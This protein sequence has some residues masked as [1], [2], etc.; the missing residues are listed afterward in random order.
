MLQT[1]ATWARK[2]AFALLGGLLM[3]VATPHGAGAAGGEATQAAPNPTSSSTLAISMTLYIQGLTLGT[4]ELTSTVDGSAYRAVSR[5]KTEGI[6]TLLWRQTIQATASGRIQ[7]DGFQP[8]LYDAFV[9]KSDGSNEQISLTYGDNGP[10][11]LFVDPPFMDSVKIEIPVKQQMESLDPVSAMTFLLAGSGGR[12]PCGRQVSVY[13]GR[14][15]YVIALTRR[16]ATTIRLDNGL[17]SGPGLQ[18]AVTYR[19]VSGAGQ[20]VLE[21]KSALPTAQAMV[22]TLTSKQT[23]RAYHVPLRLWADTPYGRVAAV[24]TSVS[25]DGAPL[26]PRK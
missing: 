4:V 21:G 1:A 18:C 10:P 12:E 15:N 6:V 7:P 19:Q 11:K 22:A 23:G 26:G 5:L 17:Y 25:L 16:A 3:L 2:P 9:V 8:A 20:K 13:D 14:R 24:A